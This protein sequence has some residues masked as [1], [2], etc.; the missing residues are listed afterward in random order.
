[1]LPQL[2]G[3]KEASPLPLAT[4]LAESCCPPWRSWLSL[5][6]TERHPLLT[7]QDWQSG[8][9][10]LQMPQ[11]GHLPGMPRVTGWLPPA[12]PPVHRHLVL[13]R[14]WLS[15]F[16]CVQPAQPQP[17]DLGTGLSDITAPLRPAPPSTAESV[18]SH[19]LRVAAS[20]LVPRRPHLSSRQPPRSSRQDKPRPDHILTGGQFCSGWDPMQHETGLASNLEKT[21]GCGNE[22]Q[23]P[24]QTKGRDGQCGRRVTE[25]A[26]DWTRR[27]R[28]GGRTRGSC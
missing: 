7:L 22:K 21:S 23:M 10:L 3:K 27:V 1:M 18:M 19:S 11:L 15:L 9:Q 2:A 5:P 4:A 20:P 25:P 16:T 28:R 12:S 26:A 17:T 8:W 24:R 6:G 13:G 14:V